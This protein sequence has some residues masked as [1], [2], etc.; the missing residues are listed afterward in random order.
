[1]ENTELMRYYNN[2]TLAMNQ[3][4]WQAGDRLKAGELLQKTAF[5]AGIYIKASDPSKI[6]VDISGYKPVPE[7]ELIAQD[8]YKNVIKK[9]PSEYW[10][11]VRHVVVE[12]KKIQYPTR[13]EV[14]LA[15]WQLCMGLD[16]LA[17]FYAKMRQ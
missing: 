11:V 4:R 15:K 6:K 12:D 1:M 17:D 16:Y 10:P 13:A 8:M 7:H 9:I 2:G 5:K 14:H 3:S